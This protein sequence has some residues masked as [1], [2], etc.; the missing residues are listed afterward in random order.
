MSKECLECEYRDIECWNSK[1]HCPGELNGEDSEIDL[2]ELLSP[3]VTIRRSSPKIGRNELCYCGSGR[4][5]KKC[6]MG[7]K[8]NE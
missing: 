4:K 2:E 5:Y 8:V 3:G 1:V 7:V 6:H